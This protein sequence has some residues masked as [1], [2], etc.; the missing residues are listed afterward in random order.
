[1]ARL[2]LTREVGV[3]RA[4]HLTVAKRAGALAIVATVALGIAVAVAIQAAAA[5]MQLP[6]KT[7]PTS[8]KV[9]ITSYTLGNGNHLHQHSSSVSTVF[10]YL[11]SGTYPT[12]HISGYYQ[13]ITA[14]AVYAAGAVY[15][16]VETCEQ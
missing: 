3:K 13:S 15:S 7:C 14:G 2:A 6:A 9:T 16:G 5:Q 1:M 4:V 12:W 10:E 8:T 11:A